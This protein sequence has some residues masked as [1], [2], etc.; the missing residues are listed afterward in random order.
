MDTLF[1]KAEIHRLL[2][3]P[4]TL[5]GERAKGIFLAAL[6]ARDALVG[7]GHVLTHAMAPLAAWSARRQ[8]TAELNGLTDRDLAD[9]G[10]TRGEIE[11]VASGVGAQAEATAR[12][13]APKIRL[14]VY[15][16]HRLPAH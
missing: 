6:R 15:A 16:P 9:I 7:L 5:D 4:R 2:P 8:S 12:A 1:T 13:K 14:Q 3:A 11:H 10:L